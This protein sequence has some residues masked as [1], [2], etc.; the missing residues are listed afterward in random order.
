MEPIRVKTY[1]VAWHRTLED[2]VA[3]AF[4]HP[5]LSD[6]RADASKLKDAVLVDACWTLFKWILRF[7]NHSSLCV[8][9]EDEK[10][11][12]AINLSTSLSHGGEFQRVG[13]ATIVLDWFSTIGLQEMDCSSLVAKRRGSRFKDL[14]VSDFGL[15]V[16]MHGHSDLQLSAAER[17]ADGRS[18]L[19]AREDE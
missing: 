19:F 17:L 2:A 15:F 16:C 11:T 6:A 9:V 4:S 7:D 18:I 10:V 3:N 8:C 14:F 12:W 1:S 5:Q 13:A